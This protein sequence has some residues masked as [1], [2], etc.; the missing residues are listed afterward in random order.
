MD[1]AQRAQRQ[2]E[3]RARGGTGFLP[4]DIQRCRETCEEPL[5]CYQE[6]CQRSRDIEEAHLLS[7]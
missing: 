7:T 3:I 2:N 6:G 1:E 4:S 5:G